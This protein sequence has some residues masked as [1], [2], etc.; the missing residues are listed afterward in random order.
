MIDS[1]FALSDETRVALLSILHEARGEAVPFQEVRARLQTRTGHDYSQSLVSSHLA[2]LR[3]AGLI[4]MQRVSTST[5]YRIRYGA[6]R[7]MK[8]RIEAWLPQ[9]GSER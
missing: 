9:E 2:I 3:A 8:E 7:D 1:F 4:E 5:T 6:I